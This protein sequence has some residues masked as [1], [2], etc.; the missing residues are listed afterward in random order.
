MSADTVQGPVGQSVNYCGAG[1]KALL[2]DIS[3]SPC[4]DFPGLSLNVLQDL[5]LAKI[6]IQQIFLMFMKSL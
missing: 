6:T 3:V 4:L 5:S 1:G 2:P